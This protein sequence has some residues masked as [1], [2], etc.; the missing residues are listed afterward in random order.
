MPHNKTTRINRAPAHRRRLTLAAAP[1]LLAAT[2][3]VANA[4][5]YTWDSSAT[6]PT[7]P[8][9]GDGN[10][11]TTTD[12]TWSNGAA[13]VLWPSTGLTN[14]AQ[15]GCGGGLATVILTTPDPGNCL[16]FSPR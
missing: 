6:H 11:N 1:A 3:A 8:V 14:I 10:W 16:P 4:Q 5:I 13:D 7:S 9:D 2:A 15:F 12:R